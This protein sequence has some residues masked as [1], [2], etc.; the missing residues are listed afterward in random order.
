[1]KAVLVTG[2]AG[3]IGKNLCATLEQDKEIEILR[4]DRKG[5]LDQL[6]AYLKKS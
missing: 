4:F 6:A 5:T 1:M 3:F 2:A